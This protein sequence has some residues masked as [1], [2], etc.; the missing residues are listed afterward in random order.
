MLMGQVPGSVSVTLECRFTIQES[1]AVLKKHGPRRGAGEKGGPVEAS[2]R[3][4][5]QAQLLR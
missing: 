1:T 2:R 5:D 3:A 4:W